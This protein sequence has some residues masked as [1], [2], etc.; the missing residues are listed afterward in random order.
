M[1]QRRSCTTHSQPEAIAYPGS[2][3]A[4]SVANAAAN[5]RWRQTEKF[6]LVWKRLCSRVGYYSRAI[7]AASMAFAPT[8]PRVDQLVSLVIRHQDSPPY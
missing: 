5:E 6:K 7:F 2:G 4:H 3:N 1:A 8:K